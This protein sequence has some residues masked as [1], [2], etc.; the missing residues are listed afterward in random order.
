MSLIKIVATSLTI[1]TLM[2]TLQLSHAQSTTS[3][4]KHNVE[5][6]QIVN[7]VNPALVAGTVVFLKDL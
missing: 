1:I 3:V 6:K 7:I 2:L 5:V 4:I